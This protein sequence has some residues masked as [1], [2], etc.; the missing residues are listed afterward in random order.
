M[1]EERDR[2]VLALVN[3]GTPIETMVNA[4][5]PGQ[6]LEEFWGYWIMERK[7]EADANHARDFY[8]ANRNM[9]DVIKKYWGFDVPLVWRG[10]KQWETPRLWIEYGA[11]MWSTNPEDKKLELPPHK[12]MKL[13]QREKAQRLEQFRNEGGRA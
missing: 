10:I 2:M 8:Y 9:R 5:F 7:G 4:L 1:N 11:Q 13:G 12:P 3:G 6:S